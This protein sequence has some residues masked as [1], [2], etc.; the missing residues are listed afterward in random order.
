MM[1]LIKVNI[2]GN[3]NPCAIVKLLFLYESVY[4][5]CSFAQKIQTVNCFVQCST[6]V[7]NGSVRRGTCNWVLRNGNVGS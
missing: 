1:F 7:G 4:I 2:Y 3:Q 5:R 6:S